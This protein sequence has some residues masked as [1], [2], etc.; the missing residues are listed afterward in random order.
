MH[1]GWSIPLKPVLEAGG[2]WKQD[3]LINTYFMTEK[4]ATITFEILKTL[5]GYKKQGRW[6]RG[7][8][9]E[10][11]VFQ[12]DDTCFRYPQFMDCLV[13]TVKSLKIHGSD[14]LQH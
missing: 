11:V 5:V 6:I 3:K 13:L 14:L 10:N 8:N 12:K 9:K 4:L 1:E 7:I 2:L